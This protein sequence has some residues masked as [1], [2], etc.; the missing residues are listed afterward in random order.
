MVTRHRHTRAS[1]QKAHG[2][3]P[4]TNGRSSKRVDGDL[5]LNLIDPPVPWFQPESFAVFLAFA[6]EALTTWMGSCS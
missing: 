6:A 4:S 5:F 2:S 1:A 3:G